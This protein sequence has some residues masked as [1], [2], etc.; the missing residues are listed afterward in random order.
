M[1]MDQVEEWRPVGFTNGAYWASSLGRIRG[2]RGAVLKPIP[3]SRGYWHVNMTWEGQRRQ[4]SVHRTVARTFLGEPPIGMEASHK[5]G[6]RDDNALANLIYETHQENCIRR[7]AHGT[8][9][10]TRGEK[11]GTAKL[12][13]AQALRAFD[14]RAAGL[15]HEAIATQFGVT[16]T[17]ITHLLAGNRWPHLNRPAS[18]A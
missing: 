16:R 18:L 11:S 1:V 4:V 12:T 14:L 9:A 7:V 17:A 13:T 3:G 8:Q 6:R 10:R 2:P 5:N 15:T